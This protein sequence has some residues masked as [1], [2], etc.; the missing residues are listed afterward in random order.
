MKKINSIW[1]GGKIFGAAVI[2]TLVIPVVIRLVMLVYKTAVLAI[3]ARI[4]LGIGV[5]ITFFFCILLTI[6]FHQDKEQN[7]YYETQKKVKLSLGNGMYECQSCGNK[8]IKSKDRNC[9]IC[10]IL[11]EEMGEES[12]KSK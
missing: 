12:E 6:E 8:T 1:Y 2:F 7:L 11:F 4:S 5:V 10:G 9:C 3:C